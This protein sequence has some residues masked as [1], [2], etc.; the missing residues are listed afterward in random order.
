MVDAPISLLARRVCPAR[1]A[2]GERERGWSAER[3]RREGLL[4]TRRGGRHACGL[5]LVLQA[6][7]P[8][9]LSLALPTAPDTTRTGQLSLAATQ[10]AGPTGLT[11]YLLLGNW[12][13]QGEVIGPG[14]GLRRAGGHCS[15]GGVSR[16][17]KGALECP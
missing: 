7:L 10:A 6:G 9:L 8:S 4:R 11:S 15:R 1:P 14:G 3:T 12:G 17:G 13:P 2:A 16:S 5:L